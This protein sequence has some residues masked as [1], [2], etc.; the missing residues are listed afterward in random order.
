[1]HLDEPRPLLGQPLHCS[2][3]SSTCSC[4]P[5]ASYTSIYMATA[6]WLAPAAKCAISQATEVYTLHWVT[7]DLIAAMPRVAP[8]A[9]RGRGGV[10]IQH[11]QGKAVWL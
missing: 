1:M 6:D 9:M 2:L 8:G 7:G 5:P 10:G 4:K 3:G 11:G